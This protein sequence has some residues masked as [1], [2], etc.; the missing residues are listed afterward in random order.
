MITILTAMALPHG[1]VGLLIGFLV[2]IIGIA[3]LAGLMYLVEEYII[4]APLP[5]LVRLIIGLVV[6]VILLI[7]LINAIGLTG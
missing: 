1:L 3:V 6:L 4:K 5:N 7:W 2:I